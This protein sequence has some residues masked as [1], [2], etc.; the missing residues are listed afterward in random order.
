MQIPRHS[1]AAVAAANGICVMGGRDEDSAAL[2]SVALFDMSDGTWSN[3]P[4]MLA[5]RS[6]MAG[7]AL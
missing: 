6:G 5:M 7:V 4:D 2:R 1:F 3:L